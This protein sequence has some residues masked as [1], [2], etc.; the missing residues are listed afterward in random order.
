M[1][2]PQSLPNLTPA[3]AEVRTMANPSITDRGMDD[4]KL[5]QT[6]DAI[7]S[8]REALR[9][10]PG[11]FA[12]LR[13]LVTAYVVEEDYS[14]ARRAIADF[15]GHHPMSGDAWRLG[16]L[17]EWKSNEREQAVAVLKRGLANLPESGMLLEQLAVFLGAMGKI[18]EAPRISDVIRNA[19]R[20][21][22]REALAAAA[23]EGAD[24]SAMFSKA[25]KAPADSTHDDLLNRVARSSKLLDAVLEAP[26]GKNDPAMLAQL[27]VRVQ[28]VAAEQPNH[29]DQHVALAR[30]LEKMDDVNGAMAAADR[31]LAAN[32]RYLDAQ[33]LR[34]RLLAR[35]GQIEPA[36]ETLQGLLERGLNWPDIHYE[37]AQLQQQRG[38]SEHARSHLYAAMH[39]NPGYRKAQSLLR[40]CA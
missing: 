15:L 3:S 38:Q 6:T 18:S 27:A 11:R 1:Y 12:V 37:I 23:G 29:A 25:S 35:A 32:P 5:C 16:A 4:L 40:Q 8:F 26:A 21:R 9:R 2:D 36:L 10:E 17:L 39:L 19:D 28:R 30:V 7:R 14:A 20:P 33:R 24:I 13:G 31:A 22:V 34:A